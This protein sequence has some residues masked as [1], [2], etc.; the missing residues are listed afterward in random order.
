MERLGLQCPAAKPWRL[1]PRATPHLLWVTMGLCP[2][3]DSAKWGRMT[4]VSTSWGGCE[5]V[6]NYIRSAYN[7]AWHTATCLPCALMIT[8]ESA[9][10]SPVILSTVGY[11][12]VPTEMVSKHNA[13]GKTSWKC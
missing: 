4:I 13:P 6:M 12:Q 5:F 10:Q 7:R 9:S 1:N 3:N 2:L 11:S 8:V